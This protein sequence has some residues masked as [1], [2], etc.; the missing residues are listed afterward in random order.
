MRNLKVHFAGLE[1][2]LFGVAVKNA[3]V[4][5]GLA[6]AYY[7]VKSRMKN[8]IGSSNAHIDSYLAKLSSMYKHMIMDS[9]VFTLMYGAEAGKKDKRTIYKWFDCLV[10]FESKYCQ[11]MSCVEVDCQK[12]LS[13][14]VAWELR[15]EMRRQLP[16]HDI[17]NVWHLEDGE[18]GLRRIAEFSNYIGIA[19]LEHKAAFGKRYNETVLNAVMKVNQINPNLRIH[20]LGCTGKKLLRA[21]KYH[22]YSSDSTSYKVDLRYGPPS[23]TSFQGKKYKYD[24]DFVMNAGMSCFDEYCSCLKSPA[25][26]TSSTIELLGRIYATALLHKLHYTGLCGDQE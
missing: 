14:E 21:C 25:Q 26:K 24:K 11:G 10:D 20:L 8:G 2:A 13:P 1:G 22:C 4:K 16:N 9:G 19:V 23:E 17:M 18:L 3:G 15:R 12:I 7:S 6:T 5:Y